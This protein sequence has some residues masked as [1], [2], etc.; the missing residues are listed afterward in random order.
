MSEGFVETGDEEAGDESFVFEEDSGEQTSAVIG[1]AGEGSED[2]GEPTDEGG[3]SEIDS[4]IDLLAG[5]AEE[6]EEGGEEDDKGEGAGKKGDLRDHPRFQELHTQAKDAK[7]DLGTEQE[8]HAET[9]GQLEEYETA[10]MGWESVF[11]DFE[12][13]LAAAQNVIA[14]A[15]AADELAKESPQHRQI[16][17]EVFDRASQGRR[18]A[19][20]LGGERVSGEPRRGGRQEKRQVSDDKPDK[21]TQVQLDRASDLIDS[22]LKDNGVPKKERT[23]LRREAERLV[24][25][26]GAITRSSMKDTVLQA[27]E[28]LEWDPKKV[29]QRKGRAKTPPAGSARGAAIVRERTGKPAAGAKGTEKEEKAPETPQEGERKRASIFDGFLRAATRSQPSG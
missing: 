14:F 6:L 8:A 3:E 29:I 17:D 22:I 21:A 4:E 27:F 12:D 23:A 20:V 25:P 10:L 24:D 1:D 7:R 5:E 18:R 9:R 16:L 13:P 2:E 15:K 26:D 28:N 11:G 19:S